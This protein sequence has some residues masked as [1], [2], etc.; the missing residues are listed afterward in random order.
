[1]NG[2]RR[3]IPRMMTTVIGVDEIKKMIAAS[4]VR[5]L[6]VSTAAPKQGQ[7]NPSVYVILLFKH[8]TS[9]AQYLR[10]TLIE[11]F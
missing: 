10:K 9:W 3:T 2:T 5:G 8:A 4:R 7:K 11:Y 6:C 1:M